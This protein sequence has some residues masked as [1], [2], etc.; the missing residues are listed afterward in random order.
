MSDDSE[1]VP[2]F[3]HPVDDV[4]E[5]EHERAI[6]LSF[7]EKNLTEKSLGEK[8]KSTESAELVDE[9]VDY[10][11]DKVEHPGLDAEYV[12]YK[13]FDLDR[14]Y[15]NALVLRNA[16]GITFEDLREYLYN[17]PTVA[18]RIGFD[19]DESFPTANTINQKAI[20]WKSATP[21]SP[22]ETYRDLLEDVAKR[23]V[24]GAVRFGVVLPERTIDNYDIKLSYDEALAQVTRETERTGLHTTIR[25]LLDRTGSHFAFNRA[26]NASQ[27]FERYIA[28]FARAVDGDEGLSEAWLSE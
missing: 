15:V 13:E 12:T 22:T 16:H 5:L 3:E 27:D 7:R 2:L 28:L 11:F 20:G 8:T 4:A 10:V 1:E 14:K 6:A 19:T 17:N 21:G 23:L 25:Y 9:F 26:S 24:W 18:E